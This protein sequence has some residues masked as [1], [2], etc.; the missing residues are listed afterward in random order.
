MILFLAVIVLAVVLGYALGGRVR[1]LE[2]LRLRWWTLALM[3]LA[4]QF[5]PLPS[6]RWGT[7]L[8]VRSTVLGVSYAM[9]L[10]FSAANVRLPGVRVLMV[11]LALNG[12]VITANGGMPVSA[13]AVARSDQ[14]GVYQELATGRSAK[15]HLANGEDILKFLGD[16]IPI[17]DPIRQ[18]VSVGD[19]FVY[20]G[21]VMLLVQ[22]MRGR[23][24]APYLEPPGHYR[25]RHRVSSPRPLSASRMTSP[26]AAT[27]SGTEP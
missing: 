12:I 2:Q 9:L 22:A 16:V 26:P 3:G 8:I 27:T 19:V 15:H 13:W 11:G 4:L 20:A 21:L 6:G 23:I 14:P 5:L 10:A 18:V 7:D 25:G 17:G 24:G 1:R